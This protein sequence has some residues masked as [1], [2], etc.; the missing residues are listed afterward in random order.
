[1]KSDGFLSDVQLKKE[2]WRHIEK[3]SYRLSK[4]AA[5]EQA[6]DDIDLCDTVHVLKTGKHN[7]NKTLF[8][9]KFQVW[10][11]AIEGSTEELKEVRVIVVFS[12]EMLI[13]TVMELK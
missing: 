13:I 4:H 5:D 9:N 10:N 12:H 6:Q 7:K 11:Y 8:N 2:I 1:M 3:G